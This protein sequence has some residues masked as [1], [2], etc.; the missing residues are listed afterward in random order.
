MYDDHILLEN[1]YLEYIV[2]P[3][4]SPF[5]ISANDLEAEQKNF[6]NAIQDINRNF[7]VDDE[8]DYETDK[9]DNVAVL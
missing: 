9:S 1:I 2:N 8:L 5:D 6:V 7:H 4:Y 3:V